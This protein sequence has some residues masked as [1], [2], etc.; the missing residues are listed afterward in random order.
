M[1]RSHR[2]A[3]R[4]RCA[5]RRSPTGVISSSGRSRAPDLTRSTITE[6]AAA[7]RDGSTTPRALLADAL[8][9]VARSEKDLNAYL[10]VTSE[11]AELQADV[12]ARTLADHPD[13]ASPLCGIPMALK[14]V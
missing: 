1:C 14:D 9:H 13:T 7:L 12:A 3:L 4:L 10:T 11:L 8:T 2:S 6:L 5:M